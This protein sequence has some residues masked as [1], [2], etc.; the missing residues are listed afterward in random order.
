MDGLLEPWQILKY[1]VCFDC[2]VMCCTVP[3]GEGAWSMCNTMKSGRYGAWLSTV[4]GQMLT[5]VPSM[6]TTDDAWRTD[7]FSCWRCQR[8]RHSLH[9]A[10]NCL[11]PTGLKRSVCTLG[12]KESHRWWQ[13]SLYGTVWPFLVSIWH[14]TLIKE[15][16]FGAE[17]WLITQNLKPDKGCVIEKLL[18]PS[19]KKYGSIVISKD[20]RGKLSWDHKHMLVLDFLDHVDTVFWLLLWYS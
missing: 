14:V 12:A 13:I 2:C 17:T 4:A 7:M 9:S 16:S 15:S 6:S 5:W 3:V 20:A 10:Q 1:E 19:N 8:A 11:G 18:S